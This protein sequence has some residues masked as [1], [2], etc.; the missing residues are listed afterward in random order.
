MSNPEFPEPEQPYVATEHALSEEITR[1]TERAPEIQAATDLFVSENYGIADFSALRDAHFSI[2]GDMERPVS[3]LARQV[4]TINGEDVAHYLGSIRLGLE[5]V[6]WSFVGDSYTG[7]NHYKKSLLKQRWIEGFDRHGDFITTVK[8]VAIDPGDVERRPLDDIICDD[9]RSLPDQHRALRER[10]FGNT[11]REVAADS[12]L[13]YCLQATDN[14]PESIFVKDSDGKYVEQPFNPNLLCREVRP[15]ADWY[16]PLD[17]CCYLDGRVILFETYENSEKGVDGV[18]EHFLEAVSF[19]E[20]NIGQRPLI[21]EIP[22]LSDRYLQYNKRLLDDPEALLVIAGTVDAVDN[23]M[24]AGGISIKEMF[25]QL[26]ES[27]LAY[28]HE[29]PEP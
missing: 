20:A 6:L 14:P 4:G 18:K 9:Q 3:I 29:V 22:P 28:G 16:Y 8:N 7:G 12:L 21:A 1:R 5:P 27:A 17:M 10:L 25:D 19:I 13:S 2:D 24:H 23:T 15:P 26:A 11:Y